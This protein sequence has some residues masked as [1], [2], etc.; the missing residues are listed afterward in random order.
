MS[1]NVTCTDLARNELVKI[2]E[3]IGIVAAQA[4][5]EPGT[6]LTMRTFHSGGVAG[7]DIT[8]GLPRVAEIL[9]DVLQKIQ[10][11]FLYLMERL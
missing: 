9:R 5:G 11:S 6:Q 3:A 2:G 10:E 8:Q 7:A 4:I 1:K